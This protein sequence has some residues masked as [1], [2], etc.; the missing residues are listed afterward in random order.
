MIWG[1]KQGSRVVHPVKVRH[2]ECRMRHL[3][4]TSPVRVQAIPL[5]TVD[6]SFQGAAHNWSSATRAGEGLGCPGCPR[7]T[8]HQ[9]P[10]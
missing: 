6:G 4:W 8:A 2:M 1:L 3:A 7:L 5:P 9:R 10:L